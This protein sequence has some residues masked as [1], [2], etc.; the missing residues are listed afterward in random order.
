MCRQFSV[1]RIKIHRVSSSCNCLVVMHNTVQF[2][3]LPI[4]SAFQYGKHYT[5]Q[6][7]SQRQSNEPTARTIPVP[8]KPSAEPTTQRCCSVL[9]FV[10]L[11]F[12]SQARL[13]CVF[14]VSS[15]TSVHVCKFQRVLHRLR[16]LPSA[17]PVL[18]THTCVCHCVPSNTSTDDD[19]QF[20]F[21][22]MVE[23]EMVPNVQ[24]VSRVCVC[25]CRLQCSFL[26]LRLCLV[27]VCL[28]LWI[29]LSGCLECGCISVRALELP[30]VDVCVCV[31]SNAACAV[32]PFT[33]TYRTTH[34]ICRKC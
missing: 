12:V 26:R 28:I 13:L 5:S 32:H 21:I 31:H 22:G 34:S 30:S 16:C 33:N 27:L 15:S 14:F 9:R 18:C 1:A 17:S 25:V 19:E 7:A 6:P 8:V 2:A 23:K 11:R 10:E 29:C 3:I 20:K 4:R 24:P